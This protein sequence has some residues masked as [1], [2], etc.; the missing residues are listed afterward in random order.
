MNTITSQYDI[1]LRVN[2]NREES[3]TE[4]DVK[5]AIVAMLRH[6]LTTN[7]RFLSKLGE[8]RLMTTASRPRKNR[9]TKPLLEINSILA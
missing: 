5:Y 7:W 4:S 3:I 1:T 9:K 6:R 2:A 8:V